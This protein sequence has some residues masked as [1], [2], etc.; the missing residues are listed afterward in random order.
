MVGLPFPSHSSSTRENVSCCYLMVV[1]Q[2]MN[3]TSYCLPI[4]AASGSFLNLFS[5]MAV[6]GRA[7]GSSQPV[8][9]LGIIL[10]GVLALF[11]L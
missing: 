3:N 10:I 7:S 11:N 2:S 8:I 5:E 1:F 4:P 9:S 6:G